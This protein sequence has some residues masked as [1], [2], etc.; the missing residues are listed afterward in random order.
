MLKILPRIA[1]TR[2]RKWLKEM[3]RWRVTSTMNAETSYTKKTP[4]R[5]AFFSEGGVASAV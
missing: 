1:Q 4:G 3:G 2:T 5:I